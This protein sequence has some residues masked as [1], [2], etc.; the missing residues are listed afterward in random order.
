MEI[1]CTTNLDSENSKKNLLDIY[2]I[3]ELHFELSEPIDT[4]VFFCADLAEENIYLY[5]DNLKIQG[6]SFKI[7]L[8]ENFLDMLKDLPDIVL[9]SESIK[10]AF[11][12]EL[13]INSTLTV[14]RDELELK[15]PWAK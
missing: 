12:I 7:R 8:E 14:V 5:R 11:Q 9:N 13:E 1:T 6:N 10:M 3:I 2:D 4:E 15:S